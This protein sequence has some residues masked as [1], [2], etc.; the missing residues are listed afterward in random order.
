MT[1]DE[2]TAHTPLVTN[3]IPTRDDDIVGMK[4]K[5]TNESQTNRQNKELRTHREKRKKK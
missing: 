3:D 1:Q 5:E 2:L 4:N